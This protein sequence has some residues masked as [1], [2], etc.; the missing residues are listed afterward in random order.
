MELFIGGDEWTAGD[1]YW[2]PCTSAERRV[3]TR[4]GSS[5]PQTTLQCVSMLNLKENSKSSDA[6]KIYKCCQRAR[7][8]DI[9]IQIVAIKAMAQLNSKVCVGTRPHSF[10]TASLYRALCECSL[11]VL[12][13]L[14]SPYF[15][16]MR[17]RKIYLPPPNGTRVRAAQDVQL[18]VNFCANS[19]AHTRRQ[20]AKHPT[21]ATTFGYSLCP[22]RP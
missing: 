12:Y 9:A 14:Y 17:C 10:V 15:A 22:I 18:F 11:H 3:G 6:F 7:N 16:P 4:R 19:V 20:W 13:M 5:H 21:N 8:S 2:P 1:D